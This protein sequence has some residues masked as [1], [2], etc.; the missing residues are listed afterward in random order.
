MVFLDDAYPFGSVVPIP[1][2]AT[3]SY[4]SQEATVEFETPTDREIF[5]F[6]FATGGDSG[7]NGN[8]NI[9][10]S[11]TYRQK[12]RIRGSRGGV[13]GVPLRHI[14]AIGDNRYQRWPG[15]WPALD[16][17]LR[18][19][20]SAQAKLTGANWT[21]LYTAAKFAMNRLF[22]TN[23]NVGGFITDGQ[24]VTMKLRSLPASDNPTS[25][26]LFGLSL[27]YVDPS[28]RIRQ[29]FAGHDEPFFFSHEKQDLA[30]AAAT[31]DFFLQ[32]DVDEADANG[33][34]IGHVQTLASFFD[35]SAGTILTDQYHEVSLQPREIAKSTKW[36]YGGAIPLSAFANPAP[37]FTA[38]MFR[39]VTPYDTLGWQGSKLV[40]GAASDLYVTDNILTLNSNKG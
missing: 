19:A 20:A 9:V 23:P 14:A 6:A 33:G 12:E 26:T 15:Y 5:V 29:L 36:S 31:L 34:E 32:S 37:A 21:Q 11:L 25:I 18:G 1:S 13:E 35:D 30:T 7:S 24:R 28:K 39:T 2:I 8:E 40:T 10:T 16:Q 38:E 4:T 3:P 27:G 17:I 22:G